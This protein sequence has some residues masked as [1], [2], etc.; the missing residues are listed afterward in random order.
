ME[1][2]G[3]IVDDDDVLDLFKTETFILLNEDEEWR[4][5][6][7]DN[8]VAAVVIESGPSVN[9]VYSFDVESSSTSTST[10]NFNFMSETLELPMSISTPNKLS[11]RELFN[12]FEIPY[13]KMP[14]H[15]MECLNQKEKLIPSWMTIV[16]HVIVTEL[17]KIANN[18][19]AAVIRTIIAQLTETY[20]STFQ[21]KD[22]DGNVIDSTNSPLFIKFVNHVNYE[23]QPPKKKK[24][25]LNISIG[26]RKKIKSLEKTCPNW[27]PETVP[28]GETEETLKEK[29]NWIKNKTAQCTISSEDFETIL[30][31]MDVSFSSQRIFFN[32]KPPY[33]K[34]KEEWSQIFHKKILFNHFEKLMD[35]TFENY[36]VNF[37]LKCKAITKHFKSKKNE[38]IQELLQNLQCERSAFLVIASFFNENI[39]FLWKNY[40][41]KILKEN[42]KSLY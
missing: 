1:C 24:L 26:A 23:N 3:S 18:I 19:P 25:N 12:T 6:S 28:E 20:P 31:I 29:Q 22:T 4:P 30:D 9:N 37:S 27:Q 33:K 38:K 16:V 2:D 5:P 11:S 17:R 35:K 40:E 42:I 36:F 34:I 7:T 21:F 8:A 14:Q 41:V 13:S 39:D 10:F 32:S 15:I